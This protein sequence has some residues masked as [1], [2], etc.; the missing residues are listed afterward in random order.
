MKCR[1]IRKFILLYSAF[2]FYQGTAQSQPLCVK[3]MSFNVARSGE[4]AQYSVVP[5]AELIR[6]YQPDVVALQE[7]DYKVN[8]SKN[9]D[10]ATELAAALGMFPVFGKAISYQGGEY[11]VAILSKYPLSSIHTYALPTP[12]GTKEERAV[13]IAEIEFP[14]G[15]NLKFASTHL[16]HS[17]D[18]VRSAMVDALNNFLLKDD[19]PTVVGGDFNAE[20]NENAISNGM[21]QWKEIGDDNPTF[22]DDPTKKIDYLFGYPKEKCATI[23]Y[24][25]IKKTGISDHCPIMAEIKFQ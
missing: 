7:V 5:F 23:S 21:Q 6:Q 12:V 22:P 19:T 2:I 10:F 4:Y 13:I 1:W 9:M 15:M 18:A 11:G 14:S 20:P 3:I 25:V 24:Q 8:R 16:D 17:S